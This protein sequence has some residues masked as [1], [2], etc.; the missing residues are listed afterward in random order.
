MT[1]VDSVTVSGAQLPLLWD[2]I[3]DHECTLCPLHEFAEHV[4]MMPDGPTPCDYMI[5]GE[6]PGQHEDEVSKRPF[7]GRAGE[8]LN[9]IL[10]EV[11]LKRSM[12]S[13]SNG[14]LCRPLNN[15]DPSNDELKTCWKNYGLK[16]IEQ[17]RPKYVVLM[18]RY[19]LQAVLGGKKGITEARGHEFT[20]DGITYLPTF[21][22]S[23]ALRNPGMKK[24]IIEDFTYFRRIAGLDNTAGDTKPEFITS[25]FRLREVI[26]KLMQAEAVAI[27]LETSGL[28][29]FDPTRK[30]WCMSLSDETGVGYV[31]PIEHPDFQ[32]MNRVG[33][34]GDVWELLKPLL[35]NRRTKIIGHNYKFDMKFMLTR[36][37]K[38]RVTFDT[39]QAA[40][41][42][43]ENRKHNLKSLAQSYLGV[44]YWGSGT[45]F[46]T[47][48]PPQMTD[49]QI[50]YSA[51]DADYDRQLY[52]KQ[53]D[54]LMADRRL[55]RVF[56]YITMP[57]V[58]ALTRIEYH[59][60]PVDVERLRERKAELERR[61][62]ASELELE[63]LVGKRI[64]WNS[65]KQIAQVL[66]SDL[67]L[68]ITALTETGQAST[69]KGAL[70]DLKALDP[71]VGE[72]LQYRKW[73]KWHGT[74]LESWSNLIRPDHP[75]LHCEY[76]PSGTVTGRISSRNPNL[77]NIPRDAFIKSIIGGVSGWVLVE[78]DFSQIELRVAADFSQDPMLRRVY[79]QH[80]D[81][82]RMTASRLFRKPPDE[83][84]SGERTLAK[85]ANFG[86]IYGMSSNKL[87]TYAK[88]TYDVEMSYNEAVEFRDIFFE[89]Y[90][91]L[92]QWHTHQ[93]VMV[94]KYG[95]VRSPLG[96]IR[97]LPDIQSTNWEVA[98]AA[99]R[100][101]INSPVQS[102]A[103]DFTLLAISLLMGELEGPLQVE[104]PALQES[105]AKVVGTVHDSVLFLVRGDMVDAV[106]PTIKGTMEHLPLQRLFNWSLA[107]PV[108]ID[109]K[110]SSHWAEED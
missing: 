15:R 33:K 27:D 52:L 21:H 102:T 55:A 3:R 43:D 92:E 1:I 101:A 12:F 60:L 50:L 32:Q 97:R 77:Q 47:D 16:I 44:R 104:Y 87:M 28:N 10:K 110:V 88:A 71:V 61:I 98:G 19:A 82:H 108:E 23:Y 59:G 109:V 64:N 72:L 6:A 40:H 5:I 29:S 94:R 86:L 30:I 106:L 73:Q 41:L 93:R 34:Q 81:V 75:L 2:G 67:G 80:G 8:L 99:E 14:V 17:V 85:S 38:P 35:E 39:L 91:A 69:S 51:K 7:T 107:V 42:L 20:K 65:P 54:E 78:A 22:T 36:G 26:D 84:T 105:V 56:Q 103:S 76:D 95:Y 31:V 4:C 79:Q 70:T 13:V 11:G 100:Q 46:A 83:I 18:G 45:Q 53:R 68:P 96:R 25:W 66:F 49:D 37:I 89:T 9:Q 90:R 63:R 58:R 74:Y 48:K 57:A 62:A 24:W